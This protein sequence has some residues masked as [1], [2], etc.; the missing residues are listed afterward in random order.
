MT[1]TENRLRDYLGAVAGSVRTDN[2]RPL[3]PPAGPRPARRASPPPATSD[4]RHGWRGWV[5]PLAAAA[6]VLAIVS[7][8]VAL[9]GQVTR[10]QP[11]RTRTGA[12]APL[13]AYYVSVGSFDASQLV[14]RSVRT[15]AVIARVPN[16]DDRRILNV[17]A[18]PDDRTFYVLSTSFT[19]GQMTV[20]S[21][22]VLRPGRA[23]KPTTIRGGELYATVTYENSGLAVSP[24]G[25]QIALTL[26]RPIV[27]T[28]MGLI[29]N[30]IILIDLRTGARLVWSGGLDRAGYT[31]TVGGLSWADNGRSLDFLAYLEANNA[32]PSGITQVRSLSLRGDNRS[33]GSST[34]LVSEPFHRNS[35]LVPWVAVTG[36]HIDLLMATTQGS[37]V[38]SPTS[39]AV[40]QYSAA[41]GRRQRVLYQ[42]HYGE[43]ASGSLTVDPSGRHVLVGLE[44]LGCSA[45]AA[46]TRS[47]GWFD[48]GSLRPLPTHGDA[49]LYAW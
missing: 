16:P 33:L 44:T 36:D 3:M 49:W 23:T 25:T 32:A 6:S 27:H 15:G 5:V 26:S 21:F 46:A 14:V 11:V 48:N 28:P 35:G 34:V 22:R 43:L 45:C 13:P 12:T 38:S 10:H 41:D 7:L 2:T 20:T 29:R 4:G 9:S 17:A 42:H 30:Q 18:A 40:I 39:L 31:V 1:T 19:T 37:T 8:S 47:A 24:D